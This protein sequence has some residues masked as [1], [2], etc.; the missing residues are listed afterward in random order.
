MINRVLLA[1]MLALGICGIGSAQQTKTN[2]VVPGV[3]HYN[4]AVTSGPLNYNVLKID[5]KNP[6]IT[7][8]AESGKDQLHVGEKVLAT[9]IREAEKEKVNVV[10]GVNADFWAGEPRAFTPVGMLVADK[11]IYKMP[12][13]K[14][15]VFALTTSEQ[16]YIG[17]ATLKVSLSVQGKA[18]KV[19]SINIPSTSKSILYTPPYGSS[20]PPARG[21]RYL[22]Q[23]TEPIF[24]PN[25]A[26]RGR[27]EKISSDTSTPLTANT[28]VFHVP[29]GFDNNYQ[30]PQASCEL[31]AVMPEVTGVVTSV[32]GG[33]P[34]IVADGRVKVATDE[35][36]GASFASTRHPRTAIGYSKDKSTVFLVTVDGRQPKISIGASLD[37]LGAA[38]V[39]IGCW[40]AMNLD[41]GGSTTMVV[42][43]KVVNSPSDATGP[44]TVANSLLVISNSNAAAPSPR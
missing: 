28:L 43:G 16:P 11:M 6:N 10:A 13:D 32:C 25:R 3:T 21:T 7:I 2:V 18:Y 8:E 36:S 22:I 40:R 38:M 37:E 19:D 33:G 29:Q 23:L 31:L 41:G 14:R 9:T 12:S 30:I 39:Q 17:K 15:S 4:F 34:A 1:A 5:L 44:R 42:D 20:V 24:L 35:G 27:I 26:A